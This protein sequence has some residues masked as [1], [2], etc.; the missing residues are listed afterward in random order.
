[1]EDVPRWRTHG[2]DFFYAQ[3]YNDALIFG[4]SSG[5]AFAEL[6]QRP[7]RSKGSSID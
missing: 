5:A 6:S 1:M 2:G 3:P 7:W 4:D